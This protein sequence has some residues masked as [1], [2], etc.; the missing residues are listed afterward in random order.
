MI[1]T[2]KD[3]IQAIRLMALKGML[4]LEIK[5]MKRRGRS[6]YSIIKEEL[7]FRGSRVRVLEQLEA[8]INETLFEGEHK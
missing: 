4:S 2:G 8:H 7:D 3:N 1:I 6:A 5:G